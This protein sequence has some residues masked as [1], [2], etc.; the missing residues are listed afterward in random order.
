MAD[1]AVGELPRATS[2]DDDSLLVMEQQGEAM[3][4]TGKTIKSYAQSAV[5]ADVAAAKSA[6][7]SA[8]TAAD[9]AEAA[10][11]SIVLDEEKMAQAASSAEE[12]AEKAAD[13]EANAK[14]SEILAQSYAEQASVP[15]VAGVYNV[16]LTDR[17]TGEK[18]ALLAESGR[19][20]LLGVSG[21][22]EATELT[23]VDANTG[24]AYAVVVD[25]GRLSTEEV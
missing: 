5:D 10:R 21:T 12:S 19:L 14:Q 23:L 24:V 3:S 20:V 22:L 11:D 16:I 6:A 8:E 13:S 18:Y 9:R 15:A 1:L 25:E 4:V 2:I 17:V 7:E